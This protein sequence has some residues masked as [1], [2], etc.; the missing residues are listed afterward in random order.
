ML[1]TVKPTSWLPKGNQCVTSRQR[2]L[3]AYVCGSQETLRKKCLSRRTIDHPPDTQLSGEW[4]GGTSVFFCK[5]YVLFTS[6]FTAASPVSF[7]SRSKSTQ[8]DFTPKISP[9][10]WASLL[11]QHVTLYS[12]IYVFWNI[13]SSLAN[14]ILPSAGCNTATIEA[15][16]NHTQMT[17]NVKRWDA[18]HLNPNYLDWVWPRCVTEKQYSKFMTR[19]SLKMIWFP[20]YTWPEIKNKYLWICL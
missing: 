14:Y 1:L 10:E 3:S 8:S 18:K 17:Q 20:Q 7:V 5:V 4:N 13:L 15:F 6:T 2:N 16:T 12:W 11:S 9:D 19:S